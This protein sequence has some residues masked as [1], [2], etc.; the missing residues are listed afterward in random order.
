MKRG[1]VALVI[2]AAVWLVLLG[3]PSRAAAQYLGQS[4]WTISIKQDEKGPVSDK[5]F[6]MTGAITRLGGTYYT[7][8]GYVTLPDDGPFILAGGGVLIGE[9]FY[10]NLATAQ[11]HT[12][13]PWRDTGVLHARVN[14]T[15]LSG[16]FYE[17]GH[18]FKDDSS[19]PS[20]VFD[21][22]FT[23][24]DITLAGPPIPLSASLAGTTSLLL[25]D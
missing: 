19:G 24:G 10:L 1:T 13:S 11:R 6:T 25:T 12:D 9:W 8:Q 21:S 3:A 14:K 16:T 23:A 22:R 17:V 20:P 4:T 18:D 5:S 7:M 2:M 15:T